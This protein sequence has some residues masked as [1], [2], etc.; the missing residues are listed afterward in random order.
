M[1][2]FIEEISSSATLTEDNEFKCDHVNA[3]IEE[4][5][6]NGVDCACN[7]LRTLVCPDCDSAEITKQDLEELLV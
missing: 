5:C 7:G 4:P 2:I 6:C 3:E 1:N